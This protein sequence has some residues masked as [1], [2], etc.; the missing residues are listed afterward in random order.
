MI[1]D[2]LKALQRA[3]SRKRRHDALRLL[4]AMRESATSDC[5]RLGIYT[6][7][8]IHA[9]ICRL[10]HD[11]AAPDPLGLTA[12]PQPAQSVLGFFTI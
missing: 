12:R 3:E 4:D 9:Y 2:R 5:M 10:L 6:P 7:R 8:R 1:G 11:Y